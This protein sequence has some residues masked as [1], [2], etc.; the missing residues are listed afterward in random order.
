MTKK[1]K[2]QIWADAD[3]RKTLK[4][5]AA[6]EGKFID[7]IISDLIEEKKSNNKRNDIFEI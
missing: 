3:I 4:T 5:M 1:R 2:V 6:K 7:E